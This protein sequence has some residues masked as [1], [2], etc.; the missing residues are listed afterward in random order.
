MAGAGFQPE[1]PAAAT[2]APVPPVQPN[3]AAPAPVAPPGPGESTAEDQRPPE[4]PILPDFKPPTS[5][6][7]SGP[8]LATLGEF[9]EPGRT[10]RDGPRSEGKRRFTGV[11]LL[12]TGPDGPT[13]V[14]G[15]TLELGDRG[16][17]L[18]RADGV[19]VWTPTW[20]EITEL[21]APERSRLPDGAHGVVVLI[22]A[23]DG[24]AHRFVIPAS[25]PGSLEASLN[26]LARRRNVSPER[27]ERSPPTLL[28]IGALV[29]LAAALAVLLLSAGHVVSL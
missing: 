4:V 20:G 25:R 8:D 19:P 22:T 1:D 3:L 16:V 15:L 5:S 24:R 21:S 14:P 17:G 23:T 7:P 13:A 29:V 28:V 12:T 2:A 11:Y 18:W 27:P 6:E 9:A 10:P 26:S